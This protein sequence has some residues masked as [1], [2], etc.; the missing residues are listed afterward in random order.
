M[1]TDPAVPAASELGIIRDHAQRARHFLDQ[2]LRG[3][4]EGKPEL[5]ATCLRGV[6]P[7]L[8]QLIRSDARLAVLHGVD[9]GCVA[10][11]HRLRSKWV[12]EKP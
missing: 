1:S 6:Q 8:L 4:D 12:E 5:T 9:G 11:A 7:H 10:E 3:I 2:I